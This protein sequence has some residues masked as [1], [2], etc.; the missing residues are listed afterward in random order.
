M[1]THSHL[2]GGIFDVDGVLLDTPHEQAWRQAIETLMTGPWQS[3]QAQTTYYPGA[4][5]SHVYQQ[6]VAGKPREEGARAALAHFGLP[7]LQGSHAAEYAALKQ[8]L[9]LDLAR[10]GAFHAYD[11]ALAFLLAL[12]AAGVRVCAASSSANANTFLDQVDVA[13][14]CAAHVLRYPF[15]QHGTTLLALFDADV[16]GMRGVPGKPDPA[17]FLAAAHALGDPPEQCFVVEDSPTGITA[18]RAGGMVSVGVA[19]HDDADLLRAAHA[20]YVV[21]SLDDIDI[22]VLLASVAKTRKPTQ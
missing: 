18:A 10:Q 9:L 22:D 11:D 6:A 19:R 2:H 21:S 1:P 13:G 5:T 7:D 4:F 3:L 15:V 12:K 20:D 8:Q 17:I 16:N 14:Y